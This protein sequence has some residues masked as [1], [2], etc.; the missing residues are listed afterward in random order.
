MTTP[1]TC[2]APYNKNC[3][4][5]ICCKVY[6]C[7]KSMCSNHS[8]MATGNAAKPNEVR[9]YMCD[10]C[11]FGIQA[12]QCLFYICPVLLIILILCLIPGVMT[13]VGDSS[14]STPNR[15]KNVN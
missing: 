6:G 8:T 3:R 4:V 11:S 13:N 1:N 5:K 7:G 12:R 9:Q 14:S 2:R 15:L 10:D